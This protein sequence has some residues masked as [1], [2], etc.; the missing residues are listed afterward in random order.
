MS[1]FFV[2]ISAYHIQILDVFKCTVF[3]FYIFS[4]SALSSR[5][6]TCVSENSLILVCSPWI[7]SPTFIIFISREVS[8]IYCTYGSNLNTC[9]VVFCNLKEFFLVSSASFLRWFYLAMWLIFL[10][11]LE[12]IPFVSSFIYILSTS[13]IHPLRLLFHSYFCANLI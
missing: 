6:V 9:S 2:H 1:T 4:S 10:P 8:S 13:D 5:G 3:S 11:F 12:P 7:I